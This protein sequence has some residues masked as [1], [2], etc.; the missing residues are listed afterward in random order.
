MGRGPVRRV[1]GPLASWEEAYR[2]WLAAQGY[3][4]WTVSDLV[5]Q[6]DGL[7]RWIEREQL[8]VGE[9]TQERVEQFEAAR[10]AAGYSMRWARCTRLPLR[11]LREIGAV[12]ALAPVVMVDG[13]VEGLLADY[14]GY[15]ARERGLAE[16]TIEN[17]GRVARLFLRDATRQIQ[18]TRHAPRVPR[19]SVNYPQ[20]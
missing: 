4:P 19:R 12:A 9:L 16:S 8:A 3:S 15:L 11:F 1:S 5:W 14:R 18:A 17:Y 13:P 2:L 10:L 6:L 20:R 7:S